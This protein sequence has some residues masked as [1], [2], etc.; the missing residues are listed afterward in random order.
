MIPNKKIKESD[1]KKKIKKILYSKNEN[2]KNQFKQIIHQKKLVDDHEQIK[3]ISDE[4]F[5]IVTKYL[6]NSRIPK[7]RRLSKENIK[8]LKIKS[9]YNY[10][11]EINKYE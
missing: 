10:Y 2:I 8:N 7:S 5:N 4:F 9:L 1:K 3:E 6:K 11:K